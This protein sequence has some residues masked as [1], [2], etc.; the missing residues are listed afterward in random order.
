MTTVGSGKREAGSGKLGTEKRAAKP[1]P[2][3][4]PKKL[5]EGEYREL[6]DSNGGL[7]LSCGEL[8]WGDCEPD[9]RNYPC[10]E[11][12]KRR[13]YGAEEDRMMGA[14]ECPEDAE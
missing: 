3:W 4:W 2:A 12:D 1:K 8:K 13:V 7:C 9:A 11:C 10:E 6:A 5:S 14:I